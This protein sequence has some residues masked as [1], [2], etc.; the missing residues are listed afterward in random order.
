MTTVTMQDGRLVAGMV[1]DENNHTITLQSGSSRD[2]VRKSQIKNDA[3]GE[4]MI[5]RS[6]FS[7]MPIGQ[8]QSMTDEQVRDLIAYLASPNQVK[9]PGSQK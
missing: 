7:L 1:V 3:A 5:L 9:L 6:E 4:P 2:S 8:L